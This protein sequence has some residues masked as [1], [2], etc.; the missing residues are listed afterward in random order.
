MRVVIVGCG[1]VGAG[2]ARELS[3]QGHSLAVVD[4]NPQAFERLGR[5]FTGKTV[6]GVGFDREVLV[7]AGVERAD[8]LAAVTASD[9]ANIVTA[10]LASQVFHVPRVVARL[11]DP[12]KAGIYRR[13]GLA[14]VSP[15]AWGINRIADM[16]AYSGLGESVSLGGGQVDLVEVEVPPLLVGRLVN[17]I[18]VPGEVLVAA[19]SRDVRT[20]IP[21]LGT[22]FQ[23]GDRLHIAVLGASSARLQQLLGVA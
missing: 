3:T 11:Y 17:D 19:I 1:R 5:T 8:A 22:V 15:V 20:V 9:E 23:D 4:R 16:L 2:L 12:G 14:T 10:R 18:T 13:L 6:A 7:G 21:T